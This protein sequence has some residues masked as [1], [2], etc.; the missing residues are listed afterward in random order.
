[1]KKWS[2]EGWVDVII[3]QLYFAT[4]TEESSFNQRLNLWSQYIYE[5]HLLVVYG[6]YKFSDP[7]Y[8][9]KFQSSEDLQKQF[10][11]AK[12]NCGI[13]TSTQPSFDHFFTSANKVL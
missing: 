8:G 10:D 1:M 2:K 7:A 6:V 13:I 4:G 5:N 12:Y 11:F 3:P 9:S